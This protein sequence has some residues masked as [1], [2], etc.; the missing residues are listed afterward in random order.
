MFIAIAGGVVGIILA[1]I[2]GG[3]IAQSQNPPR[4]DQGNNHPE[5]NCSGHCADLLAR[6]SELC[7]AEAAQRAAEERV[8]ELTD[9]RNF[10][11]A[12][13]AVVMASG[14]ALI[15]TGFGGIAGAVLV[16]VAAG[17]FAFALGL[18]GGVT[19]AE[20]DLR[21]KAADVSRIMAAKAEALK[22]LAEKCPNE[23]SG[24]LAML[25]PC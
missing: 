16:A 15:A 18:A 24:C 8:R 12:A 4:V 10:A 14:V 5:A 3:W 19:A 23:V 25:L 11:T 22:I 17:M 21:S 1:V 6:H 7:L 13:A 9:A 2:I 20:G